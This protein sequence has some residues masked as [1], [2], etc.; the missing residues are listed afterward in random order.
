MITAICPGSFDPVT[1]GHID[2]FKRATKMF[3]NV[4]V[5]VF[6]NVHKKPLFSKSGLASQTNKNYSSKGPFLAIS[7]NLFKYFLNF[8]FF[9][10]YS[11]R[12]LPQ[13]I[14]ERKRTLL[15]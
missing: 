14:L 11:C 13:V 3:D 8:R 12:F 1:N 9:A 7:F 2:I 6:N 4:I 10:V 15:Y 5:G